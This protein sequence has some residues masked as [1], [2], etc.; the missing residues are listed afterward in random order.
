MSELLGPSLLFVLNVTFQGE[1]VWITG[2]KLDTVSQTPWNITY[3]TNNKLGPSN[4][5]TLKC[6]I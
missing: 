5:D 6:N 4:S 3:K 1:G 2:S